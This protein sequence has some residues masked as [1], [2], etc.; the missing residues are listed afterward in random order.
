MQMTDKIMFR[1]IF[2]TS[3]M[4][5]TTSC[6]DLIS[7]YPNLGNG[8]KFVHEGKYGLS[9]VNGENTIVIGQCVLD[10]AYD[11]TFVIVSQRPFNSIR[12]RD[13][14]TYSQYN[15][16]FEN[17]SF[18][19]YWIID[20]TKV[21]KHFGFDSINQISRYSNVFGPFQ[22]KVYLQKRKELGISSSLKLKE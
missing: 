10:Y 20:K 11:S 8:Y 19:Q 7:N 18:K 21:C 13:T 6:S 4:L 5:I 22:K 1:L 3:I 2:Y 9:I 16:A 15:K 17:G 14:M 12:G